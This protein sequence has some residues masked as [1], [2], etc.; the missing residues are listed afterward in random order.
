MSIK[1]RGFIMPQADKIR[2]NNKELHQRLGIKLGEDISFAEPVLTEIKAA[3]EL[4]ACYVKTEARILAKECD[5][6]FGT[7]Q[8]ELLLKNL[9]G[10]REVYV[11]AATLGSEIDRLLLK[12]EALSAYELFVCDAVSSAYIEA[13]AA[14]VNSF[15]TE[16]EVSRPRFSPGFGG[17]GL[18][19]QNSIIKFLNA[20]RLLGLR[21]TSSSM[22]IPKKSVTAVIGTE[23]GS[24]WKSERN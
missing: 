23:G 3:A 11:F 17:F 5:L 7:I 19:F 12:K 24:K 8:S 10:C 4:K 14:Y 13:F 2:I 21:L 15:L 18:E 16:H 1:E 9:Y 20:D 22:I 6:G